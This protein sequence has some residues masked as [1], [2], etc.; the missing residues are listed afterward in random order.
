[1]HYVQRALR[2][3]ANGYLIKQAGGE[4]VLRAIRQVLRGETYLSEAISAGI[5]ERFSGQAAA[6]PDSPV[7]RLSDRELDVL[8]LL[9]EGHGPDEIALLLCLNAKT[10]ES[11]CARLKKK[12][13]L[14]ST[15]EL[16]RY[17]VRCAEERRSPGG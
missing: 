4:L 3:G 16:I 1:M 7:A 5:L 9:G 6:E 8:Q 17:A 11:H 2:A 14:K 10:V 15:A 13:S 12:L